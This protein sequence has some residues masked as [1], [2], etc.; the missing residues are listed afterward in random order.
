MQHAAHGGVECGFPQLI[1]VHF[2]EAFVALDF[3]GAFAFG[4]QGGDDLVEVFDFDAFFAVGEVG[5]FTEHAAHFLPEA[6]DAAVFVAVGKV[7]IDVVVVLVGVL[8]D[9]DVNARVVARQVAGGEGD[10]GLNEAGEL[11]AVGGKP[12]LHGVCVGEGGAAEFGRFDERAQ[13]AVVVAVR[14]ALDQAVDHGVFA[15]ECFEGAFADGGGVGREMQA[16]VVQCL[17]EQ[18]FVQ[19]VVVFEVLFVAAFAGAVERRLGD[20]DVAAFDEFGHLPVE[21][22]EE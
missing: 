14:E 16:G 1:G 12:R 22:G 15:R 6:V 19:F 7:R 21:E 8:F 18:Q 11:L 5:A 9:A 17:G 10:A 2:T 4:E 3:V 20:V 13:D